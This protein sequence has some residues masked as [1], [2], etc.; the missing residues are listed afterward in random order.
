MQNDDDAA[1]EE[2]LS[3]NPYA[4][5]TW[6]QYITSKRA[7]PPR[8]SNGALPF[9]RLHFTMQLDTDPHSLSPHTSMSYAQSRFVLWE[10]ALKALPGS[11]K[12]WHGYLQD[13]VRHVEGRSPTDPS[14]E[15]VNNA[16]ERALVFMH[17]MPVVWAEYCA[18][19]VPQWRLTRIR[20]TFD[21]ALRAL[22]VTQHEKI[23]PLYLSFVREAGVRETCV[24]VYRRYLQFDPS[25]REEYVEYLLGGGGSTSDGSSGSPSG[26]ATEPINVDEAALQIATM[27]NDPKFQS[28]RG[29]TKHALWLQLCELVSSHPAQVTSLRVEPVLRSGIR[30]FSDEVGRLWCALGEYFVRSGAFERA[31]DVYEEAI[32]EVA[33]VRDFATV[34][35]AYAQFE[36]AMLTARLELAAA[37]GAPAP[38][39]SPSPGSPAAAEPGCVSSASD[40]DDL[41]LLGEA[42]D[43]VE[44]RV[45]RLE[46]LMDRRPLLLS[47]V[48]LRQNPHNV[49]EWHK[50]A[51]LFKAAGAPA[52]VVATYSEAVTT[53]DPAQAVG[54]PHTLWGA[55]AR[56]YE[57]HGDAENARVVW[58][59]ATGAP[60]RTAED[61]AAVWC[62]WGEMELRLQQY[63]R[64]LGLMEEATRPYAPAGSTA[65]RRRAAAASAPVALDDSADLISAAAAG[66]KSKPRAPPGAGSAAAEAVRGQLCKSL[67]VWGLYLD[68]EESL[69]TVASVQGAYGR[70]IEAGVATPAMVL[71]GGT[72]LWE[73][74]HFEDAFRL[75]EKS[76][77]AFPWPHV[78]DI[79]LAYLAGFVERYGGSKLERCRDLFEQA[80]G[81]CPPGEALSLHKLYARM[82]EAH[83]SARHAMGV[84]D[85][86]TRA[87]DEAH[88]YEAYL[89]Y[90]AAAEEAFG[91][92]RTRE[93]YERAVEAIPEA[94]VRDLCLR[95]AGMEAKL[96][97]LDRSRA[98]MAHASNFCDPRKDPGFWKE[99]QDFEVAH[100]NEDTF[101]E[102]LRV[103]RSVAAQYSSANYA[104]AEMLGGGAQ[105]VTGG[106]AARALAPAAPVSAAAGGSAGAASGPL[107]GTKRP[108]SA[109]QLPVRAL[110]QPPAKAARLAD[111]S[112]AP[113]SVPAG[114]GLG[115]GGDQNELDIDDG[116]GDG[117]DEVVTQAVPAGV[118]G[119]LAS[120]GAGAASG[121]GAVQPMGALER[122]RQAGAAKS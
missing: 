95:F 12:L 38:S 11:Y 32:C 17:K 22:P 50:R 2:E 66:S 99:W 74:S 48:L 86:A 23:W 28:L 65:A 34:F 37:S 94:H 70:A 47:S 77:A 116:D 39:A 67:R 85:R 83:G 8:V 1:Y 76:V 24:R 68:L 106:D 88:R 96:G 69:G 92:P 43:D 100:G 33:T 18:F 82:E 81:G 107:A 55:F 3:R 87:C 84:Y 114:A 59:Q 36:E 19:L 97:E 52:K 103:K 80:V 117:G 49:H 9:R 101:R 51:K 30:R 93:I 78:K 41:S 64:A 31:R 112:A 58:K 7:A 72:Y 115:Y 118:F 111:G 46:L 89:T 75:Y 98:I 79:W 40:L 61:L 90:I 108:A 6:I 26:S 42:G 57:E 62:E 113:S 35:D 16:F 29:R 102:M 110:A 25:A 91:A 104:T 54:K 27:V 44:L 122:F 15:V 21:R 120:A 60:F 63:A 73:R 5:K 119:G 56:F 105:A 109:V 4:L 71:N 13:R 45:A 10:R 53:V 20:R 121:S 14:R